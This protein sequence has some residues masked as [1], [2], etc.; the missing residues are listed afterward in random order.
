MKFIQVEPQSGTFVGWNP[1][2]DLTKFLFQLPNGAKIRSDGRI[3]L[4]RVLV[5]ARENRVEVTHVWAQGQ[6]KEP[7]AAT[8][9]VLSGFDQPPTIEL[10]GTQ[11]N[12]TTRTLQGQLAYLVPLRAT[13]R[14]I[15][16]MEKALR[17]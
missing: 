8:T 12:L 15:A 14:S 3:G 11:M 17:D 13:T 9:L 16:E 4:A 2:P 1:L 7:E 6:D 10:N 5:N